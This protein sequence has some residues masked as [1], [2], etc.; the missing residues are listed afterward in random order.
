M[1]MTG[2]EILVK[3]LIDEGVDTVL[4][5]NFY[6]DEN[7]IYRVAATVKIGNSEIPINDEINPI[8]LTGV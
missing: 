1:L 5:Y 3:S 4:K 6:I 7:R 2:A 8:T